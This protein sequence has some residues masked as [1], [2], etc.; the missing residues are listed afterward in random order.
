MVL[1]LVSCSRSHSL[2]L[3]KYDRLRQL[4]VRVSKEH[5]CCFV[6]EALPAQLS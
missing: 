6:E 4:Q 2:P 5:F 1:T 3:D